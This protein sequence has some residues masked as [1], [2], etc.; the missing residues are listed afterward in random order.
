MSQ[1]KIYRGDDCEKNIY[2]TDKNKVPIDITG[3]TIHFTVK[4]DPVDSDAIALIKKDITDHINPTIGH[5]VISLT[6]METN[7]SPK[8][9]YYDI[10]TKAGTKIR[11]ILVGEFVIM[12]NISR[13]VI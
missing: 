12:A 13:R 10:Q 4:I 9:Y 3:W 7:Q 5:S 2:F 11:T 6:G 1:I 8:T